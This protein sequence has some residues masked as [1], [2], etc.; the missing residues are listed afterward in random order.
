MSPDYQDIRKLIEGR[1]RRRVVFV[2]HLTLFILTLVIAAWYILTQYVYDKDWNNLLYLAVWGVLLGLHWAY[3][4]MA[5]RRDQEVER[6]WYHAYGAKPPDRV[7][8]T[9]PE[10]EFHPT[11]LSED[12][13]WMVEY[14]AK[15]KPKRRG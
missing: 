7:N 11:R 1:F 5:K 9:Y 12:G 10:D 8:P 4:V 15:E 3:L 2:V 14:E 6:A 13:D